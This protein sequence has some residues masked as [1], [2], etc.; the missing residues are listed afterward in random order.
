MK[1]F[2]KTTIEVERLTPNVYDTEETY[3]QAGSTKGMV[4]TISPQDAMISEGNLSQS[5]TLISD[6]TFALKASDRLTIK[7]EKYIVRGTK[8]T[9][10]QMSI[11]LQRSIIEKLNS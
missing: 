8:N 9:E 3:Y 7:G 2:Y 1:I 4:L 10:G 6:P 11:R 5:S